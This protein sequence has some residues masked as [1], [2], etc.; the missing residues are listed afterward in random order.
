MKR[1]L[2]S[3]LRRSVHLLARRVVSLLPRSWRFG[4]ARAMVD[5]DFA[6]GPELQL[7]IADTRE[8][9]E[10]CFALLHDAYVGE[11]YMAP[12]PSGLRVTAYH[13]LPTTTTLCAKVDGR[14]VGTLSL[15]REGVF[16]FPMQTAFDLSA[17]RA[18]QG[19]IAEVSALAVH[20]DFRGTGGR[21]LFPL[22]KFM[23]DYCTSYFD[24]RHLVIAVNPNKI[25]MYEALLM[26]ER[27]PAAA[28]DRY[29]FAN[30]APAVGATLDLAGAA[31]KLRATYGKRPQQRNLHR[32]FIEHRL[33]NVVAPLRRYHTTN[34][35]V[36]TE[37][38]IEHFFVRR[39][40][41][42]ASM[43]ARRQL[44]LRSMYALG[45]LPAAQLSSARPAG[46]TRRAHPRYS[47][48]FPACWRPIG[49]GPEVRLRLTDLSLAGFRAEA[50]RPLPAGQRGWLAVELGDGLWSAVDAT[51]VHST[52]TS[53]GGSTGARPSHGFRIGSPDAAWRSCVDALQFGR[54][55]ADLALVRPM[56][57]VPAEAEVAWS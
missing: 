7:K 9:L 33:P 30:G 53:Q 46:G 36:M 31:D 28:V 12:D 1:S 10:A 41:A 2:R 8:E 39:T 40:Q 24:T 19:R 16:G 17:V 21:I 26:F 29:D 38:L 18:K 22:M 42:Y 35:P 11:G 54:T 3:V 20:R 6:P 45:P 47:I 34:D 56:A 14:V 37:A 5:C 44:L 15:I 51:V 23:Y 27:L 52:G 25:E 48:S 55:H 49:G 4:L 32:Y 50:D 43:D 57:P 13:A